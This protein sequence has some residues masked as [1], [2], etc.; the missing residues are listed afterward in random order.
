MQ[1]EWRER[2]GRNSFLGLLDLP[3][4]LAILILGQI[5]VDLTVLA[6]ATPAGSFGIH[7]V[8]IIL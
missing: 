5:P 1:V 3:G 4:W 7:G 6:S 2:S 8:D